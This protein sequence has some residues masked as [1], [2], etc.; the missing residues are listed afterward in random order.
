[1]ICFICVKQ[2]FYTYSSRIKTLFECF[3]FVFSVKQICICISCVLHTSILHSRSSKFMYSFFLF[4]RPKEILSGICLNL[5]VLFFM[6]L[7]SENFNS[8]PTLS[9]TCWCT[10][11]LLISPPTLSYTCWCTVKL[12]ISASNPNKTFTVVCQ[13]KKKMNFVLSNFY[14]SHLHF[15]QILMFFLAK[16]T[17]KANLVVATGQ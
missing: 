1:M 6:P 14:I 17:P 9:Y 13:N 10:V 5:M 16:A 4:M 8:T 12:F 3:F 2:L 7:F 15:C 11:K